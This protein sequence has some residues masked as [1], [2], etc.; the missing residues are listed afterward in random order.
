MSG[1]HEESRVSDTMTTQQGHA[2]VA[3]EGVR[4]REH[5]AEDHDWNVAMICTW[6][7]HE[8]MLRQWHKAAHGLGDEAE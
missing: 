7:G 6:R 4:L 5:L 1:E 8:G 3:L 2:Y